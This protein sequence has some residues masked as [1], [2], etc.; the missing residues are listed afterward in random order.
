MKVTKTIFGAGVAVALMGSVAAQA[1]D[2][3]IGVP[4]WPSVRVTAHVLKTVMEENLGVTM[5][6]E[7]AIAF[8]EQWLDRLVPGKHDV[9]ESEASAR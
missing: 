3:V 8:V 9:Q 4:N 1:A 6:H 7:E 2:V 5:G